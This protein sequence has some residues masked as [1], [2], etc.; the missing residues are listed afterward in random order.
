MP[1]KSR[2]KG[3]AGGQSEESVAPISNDPGDIVDRALAKVHTVDTCCHNFSIKFGFIDFTLLLL[4]LH[5]S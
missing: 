1:K 2:A 4:S 5:R 3:K